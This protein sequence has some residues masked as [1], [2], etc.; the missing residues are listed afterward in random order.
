MADMI[1][2]VDTA[3]GEV[4]VNIMPLLD[5]TDFKTI[6]AAVVFNQAGLALFWNFVTVTGAQTCT[7]VTPT[8]GG[9]YDW[10]DQGTSGMYAIEMPASGGASANN[11]TEGFGWFT[12]VAT[13]ILPWRGPVIQFS[14]ANITHGLVTGTEWFPADAMGVE[15]SVAAGT[16]TVKKPD[17]S[18][19]AYTKTVASDPAAEPITGTS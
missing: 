2:V 8:S 12:G 10:T 11:D 5:D 7:A 1:M 16:L 4:P 6:E 9:D 18:T 15:F 14:P 19:T 13:G 3:L 17:G